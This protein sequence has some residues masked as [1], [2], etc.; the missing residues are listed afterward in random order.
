MEPLNASR[1]GKGKII[2]NSDESLV[3]SVAIAKAKGICSY[4]QQ[5]ALQSGGELSHVC[6]DCIEYVKNRLSKLSNNKFSYMYAAMR[7]L[8]NAYTYSKQLGKT[9]NLEQ[10][11]RDTS[12]FLSN[13]LLQKPCALTFDMGFLYEDGRE[14]HNQDWDKV[15][16]YKKRIKMNH[17]LTANAVQDLLRTSQTVASARLESSNMRYIG[18]QHLTIT[19]TKNELAKAKDFWGGKYTDLPAFFD[20]SNNIINVKN[21]DEKCF[22]WSLL[23]NDYLKLNLSMLNKKSKRGKF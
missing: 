1:V 23:A 12:E 11:A 2:T 17:G 15:V 16:Y 20:K 7:D 9:I 4:C 13:P 22:L 6:I 19:I 21:G 10:C 14:D 8:F 5:D 3:P 18:F